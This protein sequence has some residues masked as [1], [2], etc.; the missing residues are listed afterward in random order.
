MVMMVTP[1]SI[2]IEDLMDSLDN[3]S[4]SNEIVYE[5]SFTCN[6]KDSN[7]PLNFRRILIPILYSV[8]FVVGMGGNS[9]VLFILMRHRRLRSTTDFFLVHLAIADLLMLITFPFA[10][11]EAVVG[12]IFGSFLCKTVGFIS[13][14]NFYCSSILLGCISVDRYLSIIHAI[15][16]FRKQSVAAVH[17]PCLCVWVFCFLL[18][19]PNLFILGTNDTDNYTWCT[20]HDSNF[21]SNGWWQAGR[22]L[23]HVVGFL[24]PLILMSFC[25]AHIIVALY[26]SPRREK[27]RAVRVA[28]VITGVFLL[29]W[30]PYNVVVLLDT[31][32][33]VGLIQSCAIQKQLPL[34]MAISELLGYVH[35]CL[36]PVLYAFV[37]VKFRNDALKV[38]KHAGCLK[39]K[40]QSS[41]TTL[42]RKGS[43]TESESGTV[44]SS[45]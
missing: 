3:T 1:F 9:L 33:Q 22:I 39:S 44:M 35:C 38:L 29:C 45:F 34:A 13:R 12:W 10:V 42:V 40:V 28:I 27:K 6:T 18:S 2:E 41:V 14:L 24:C 31:L 43:T 15:Y 20:Y 32:N 36:N 4:Y 25:Y 5:G 17:I 21:P 16:A 37:G 7:G 8:V 30:T 19:L 23:N 26:K 11:S